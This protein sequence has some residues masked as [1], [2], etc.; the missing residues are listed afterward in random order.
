[1]SANIN[2]AEAESLYKEY[3]T[4]E[5]KE[6]L[7]AIIAFDSSNIKALLLLG[8]VNHRNQDFGAAINC[9]EKVLTIDGENKEAK[10]GISLAQNILQLANNY[11]FENTYTDDEL[12]DFNN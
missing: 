7:D 9:F 12:Y 5:A 11:Y 3:K 2:F 4:D 6:I 8:K 10:I 1:M